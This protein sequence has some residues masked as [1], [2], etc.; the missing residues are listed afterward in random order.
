MMKKRD[1]GERVKVK[2]EVEVEVEVER[3]H[4]EHLT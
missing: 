4:K 3:S 2:V 1:P